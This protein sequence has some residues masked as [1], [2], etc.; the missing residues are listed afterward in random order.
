VQGLKPGAFKL[1][2]DLYGSHR[3]E[4]NLRVLL[5]Q[6]GTAV[7]Q[8]AGADLGPLGV[9]VQAALESKGSETGRAFTSYCSFSKA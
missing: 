3:G 1:W 8:H 6:H 4:G 7:R 2:V 5:K 9:A